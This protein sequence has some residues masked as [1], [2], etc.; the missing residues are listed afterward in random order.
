MPLCS[1]TTKLEAELLSLLAGRL[2]IQWGEGGLKIF[3]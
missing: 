3:E 2:F 1:V